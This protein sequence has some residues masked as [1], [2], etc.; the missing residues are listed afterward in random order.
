MGSRRG[1]KP[2]KQGLKQLKNRTALLK[3]FNIEAWD[4][5]THRDDRGQPVGGS[6]YRLI[7]IP[8]GVQNIILLN[9]LKSGA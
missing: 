1:T 3:Y 5:P 7:R 9:L 2:L 6:V 4:I 8:L